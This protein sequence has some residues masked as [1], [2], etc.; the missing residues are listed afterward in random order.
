MNTKNQMCRC[1]YKGDGTDGNGDADHPC[2]ANGYSCRRPAKPRLYQ[3][4]N[5]AS[6]AGVQLKFSMQDT[7][8]CDECWEA[9]KNRIKANKSH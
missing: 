2:H 4:G 3:S 5:L 6:L 9:F 7:W 1:G 8:A